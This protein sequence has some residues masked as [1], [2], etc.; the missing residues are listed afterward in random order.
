[1][2]RVLFFLNCLILSQL[3]VYGQ[4]DMELDSLKFQI[5][6]PES[7]SKVEVLNR[8]SFLLREQNI[9]ESYEYATF[10]EQL[11][12]SEGDSIN[13]GRAKANLGWIFYR[14]GVWDKAFR[15]SR[16]AF[17]ISFRIKDKQGMAMSLNNLG[18]IYYKQKNYQEAI[19][20]F[21]EAYQIGFEIEDPYVIIR[22]FNNLA[23]N[24]LATN[25]LDSAYNYA[26]RALEIN[27]KYN[28][29]YYNSFIY[30]VIGDIQAAKGSIDDALATYDFALL[31]DTHHRLESF[32]ASI[33]NRKGKAYRLL[34]QFEMAA[35]YLE[36]SKEI[37]IIKNYQEELANSYKNL[38]LT[39]EALNKLDL[40]F[41]NQM[42]YNKLSE[43][44]EE[45]VNKDRLALISAM[46]EVEKTDAE[47][48]YLR[49]ENDFK[50]LQIKSFKTY[51]NIYVFGTL[52]LGILFIWLFALHKKTKSINL[53]LVINQNKVN[54]QKEEL[55]KQ[56]KDLERSNKLKN[57]LF[58]I[59]GHDLKAPVAQLQGVLGLMNDN[60]LSREEFNEISYVLKR[61]VDGLFVTLDN[62]LS[63]SRA[64]MDGFKLHL[65][66]TSCLSTINQCIELLQQHASG[67]GLEFNVNV[68]K[69][70]KVWV[71]HDLFQIILRNLISNAIK[72]SKKNSFIDVFALEEDDCVIIKVKDYGMG[73]SKEML[74]QIRNQK[75]SLME[76]S[77]GTDN[78]RG[79]GLGVNLCKEFTNMMGGTIHFES[80]RNIGTTVT[81]KF[82]K[83]M[84][85]EDS[86]EIHPRKYLV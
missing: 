50:E 32:E 75:F 64:Q 42:A 74:D 9:T 66:P 8:L 41:H 55:E 30:R 40:A 16:D 36:K 47:L 51:N 44:L 24:F 61:N 77:K 7:R 85:V 68:G 19:K 45:K 15:Y 31:T 79:T 76:S 25:E 63:W 18:V 20:K 69:E 80:A 46:F 34:G 81:L 78:E 11:A 53:A 4:S 49:A 1:M 10:A 43:L 59:L 14:T 38:A 70:T 56:S 22:S 3:V 21:R 29:V 60:S 23:L 48:R 71:D 27:D 73:M 52:I 84:L 5:E 13:L 33:L 57:R 54:Q 86:Q 26:Y 65:R 67:K 6:A 58:S 72:Y 2:F 17:L 62:I 83:V 35:E 82:R 28:S 39:Y 37:S 12:I